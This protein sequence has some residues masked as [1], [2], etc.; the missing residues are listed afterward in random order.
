MV[1]KVREK[2]EKSQ[3]N[4]GEFFFINLK[5]LEKGERYVKIYKN[6]I[7]FLKGEAVQRRNIDLFYN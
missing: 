4:V 1:R 5:L 7:S 2:S 6:F 3:R